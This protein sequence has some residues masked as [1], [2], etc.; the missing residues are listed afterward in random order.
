VNTVIL[1][2]VLIFLQAIALLGLLVIKRYLHVHKKTIESRVLKLFNNHQGNLLLFFIVFFLSGVIISTIYYSKNFL[3][4]PVAI[5]ATGIVALFNT[6]TVLTSIAFFLTQTL[7]FYFAYRYRTKPYRSAQYITGSPKL[8]L[9]WTI[10]PAACFIFL[11]LWGQ[12]L[13]AKITTPPTGNVLTLEVMGQQFNWVVRYPGKDE[14]LGRA[15]F[16]FISEDNTIGI[17]INDLASNDDFIPLQMHIPKNRPVKLNLRSKD[18][19][20]SFYIPYFRTK[21]DA[22]PGMST[23]L[24]F[25]ATTTTEEMREEL[26]DPDFNYEVAC[27]ELCGRMHFVMKLILIVDEPEE[28]DRWNSNQKSWVSR[29]QKAKI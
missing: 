19:I 6:T 28:F 2:G 23:T 8:E 25:T 9:V 15:V 16:D 3:P 21:M 7:L 26:N 12:V 4:F 29:K 1:I 20:H 13:W 11:F 14:K 22:L 10:I 18:V 24:H 5:P 17:D 27:A